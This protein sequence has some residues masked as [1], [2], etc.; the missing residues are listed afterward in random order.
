MSV[1]EI[2]SV[3]GKHGHGPFQLP[4]DLS[5]RKIALLAQSKKGKTYG[6]G[7]ILEDMAQLGRPFIAV[8]PANN[9]W[10]L[11][12]LPDGRP[13]G[14][15]VVIIGGNHAD[16][17]FEKDQGERMAELLI[18]EPICS[19]IDIAFE[20]RAA[21]RKFMTDFSNRLMRSKPDAPP[22]VVLEECP[23]LIPQKAMGQATICKTAVSQLAT[24]GGNYG[25]GILAACQRPATMDKDVLSQ[26]DA[27]IVMGITHKKDRDT[28]KDWIEAKDIDERVADCF[29]E[30]GS[31]KP[32]EAW[33]WSP[34]E[35]RF[36]K[37]LFR[38]R[39][40]L[41]PREMQ[42][43]GLNKGAI[44][45]GDMAAFVD[46]A[47]RELTKTLAPV[48]GPKPEKSKPEK[49]KP[50]VRIPDPQH[51]ALVAE[52]E[53]LKQKVQQLHEQLANERR[54]AQ[55]AERRLSVVRETLRPQYDSLRALF[56][57]LGAEKS[58][59]ADRS[60]WLVWL[61]KAPKVGMKKMLEHLIENGEATR[62]QLATIAGVARTTSYDYIGW[63]LRN[64]LAEDNGQ[65]IVLR[66]M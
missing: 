24:I 39:R 46:R 38:K 4:D 64:Q 8:D 15:E 37:F 40:T 28:I 59:V 53:N 25:Y 60:S 9:L 63:I 51:F 42:K 56:E 29:K 23:V 33:Y 27:L 66:K 13:S 52:N 41:H 11:R 48:P 57:N 50:E 61:E 14:L 55:S 21:A 5:D 65:K 32:G 30:L 7:D 62:A 58:S 36:E 18:S 44:K 6:L 47:K 34:G 3:F 49:L 31:L 35:E 54:A 17:P 22:L 16:L 2:G 10:G 19:V 26:C 20:P 45:L 43:I 12:V 1:L